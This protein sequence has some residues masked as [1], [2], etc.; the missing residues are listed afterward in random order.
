MCPS[1]EWAAAFGTFLE[2]EPQSL[3]CCQV[4][5]AS[6]PG[7]RC[8]PA[9][10][11]VPGNSVAAGLPLSFWPSSS[12]TA[13]DRGR[14]EKGRWRV[15]QE[16]L[17]RALRSFSS[18]P[19]ALQ[20]QGTLRPL[21]PRGRCLRDLEASQRPGQGRWGGLRAQQPLCSEDTDPR[22]RIREGPGAR[23]PGQQ[24]PGPL[25]S[26]RTSLPTHTGR[27]LALPSPGHSLQEESRPQPREVTW[28]P[29]PGCLSD[30]V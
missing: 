20:A 7:A 4:A 18:L 23:H 6:A 15:G 10:C 5:R 17:P 1:A 11:S 30:A 12:G 25:T 8:P 28:S 13:E 9:S 29:G 27:L 22:W 26:A 2:A 14:G 24:D 3:P 16:H 19:L 21:G